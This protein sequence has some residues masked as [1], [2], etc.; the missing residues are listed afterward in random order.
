MGS[1]LKLDR[2][3]V[4]D[5]LARVRRQGGRAT[6]VTRRVVEAMLRNPERHLRAVDLV[7]ECGAGEPATESTIYR[8]LDR[9]VAYG[10][11]V[12]A[13]LDDGALRFHLAP[14][15]HEHLVCEACGAIADVP[16]EVLDDVARR[17]WAEYG[18]AL[19]S[20]AN[21]LRGGCAAC[22]QAATP[23]SG[24]AVPERT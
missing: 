2:P 19:R 5:V 23:S 7:E 1:D 4:D 3:A 13:Q 18:F 6:P 17:L 10:V 20:G 11:L 15:H 16:A 9:L 12:R 21:S 8:T 14:Q 24:S 22:R